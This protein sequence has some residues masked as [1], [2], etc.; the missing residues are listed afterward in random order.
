MA[1]GVKSEL[2]FAAA[3]CAGEEFAREDAD[4]AARQI[5]Q[6][7]LLFR[8]GAGLLAFVFQAEVLLRCRKSFA[9]LPQEMRRER[10]QAWRESGA[11]AKRDFAALCEGLMIF[12]RFSRNE[13]NG[14]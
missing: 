11:R 6:M 12:S 14:D 8:A 2:L 3:Q 7:P 1:F 4:F 10:W 13:N 5:K 9:K